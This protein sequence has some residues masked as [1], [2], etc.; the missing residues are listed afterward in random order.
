ML[1][2]AN[3]IRSHGVPNFPDPSSNGRGGIAIQQSQRSGSGRSTE[4]NGVPVNGPAFQSAMRACR[5]YEPNGGRPSAAKA[6]Q[7]R[8]QALATARCMRSHGVPN[9]PDPQFRTGPNGGFG[10]SLGGAGVNRQSPAFQAAQRAC[11]SIFGGAGPGGAL[12][13]ARVG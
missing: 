13:A 12:K 3:C 4:V 8:A 7:I 5:R 10:I 6:A 1:A 2:F 9:F 11:G